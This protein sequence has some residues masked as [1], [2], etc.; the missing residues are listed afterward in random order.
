MKNLVLT[1]FEQFSKY[2]YNPTISVVERVTTYLKNN[3]NLN[4]INKILQCKYSTIKNEVY[5]LYSHK[6]DI[7]ISLGL[8]ASRK[9]LNLEHVAQNR[10][11]S[12]SPDNE[13]I[14]FDE[15]PII[16]D[17][18]NLYNS[19]DLNKLNTI[20]NESVKSEISQNAG[21][22]MCN[23]NFYWNQYKINNEKLNTKFLF[24]HIPFTDKYKEIEPLI[25][26]EKL[27]ILS[28]DGIVAAVKN[29]INELSYEK[30]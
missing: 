24:I 21:K 6:P 14:I 16:S 22:F 26:N 29:I 12:K 3:N 13:G 4:I 7:I 9:A 5:N 25:K 23:A 18:N 19:L 11:S 15:E 1:S 28:E 27:P 17:G 10:Y 8:G 30:Q 20:S 2:K